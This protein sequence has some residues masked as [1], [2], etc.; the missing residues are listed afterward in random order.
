MSI[1]RLT[2]MEISRRRSPSTFSSRSMISRTR[3]VSS[4]LQRLDPLARIHAGLGQD[5][6]GGGPPDP[7]DVRD[8]HLATLLPRQSTPAT[9]AMSASPSSPAAACAAGSCR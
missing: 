5:P 6:V 4:S 8:R 7:V 2:F 9:R 1:S 3:A